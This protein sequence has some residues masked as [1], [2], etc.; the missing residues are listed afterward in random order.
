MRF[1]NIYLTL[2]S[3]PPNTFMQNL[4]IFLQGKKRFQNCSF[5]KKSKIIIKSC[6]LLYSFSQKLP[7]NG[8]FGSWARSEWLQSKIIEKTIQ[9]CSSFEKNP[10]RSITKSLGLLIFNLKKVIL[11]LQ[12]KFIIIFTVITLQLS[13]T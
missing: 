8:V 4:I 2:L 10:I 3:C 13:F 6:P 5:I 7:I 11:Q 1:V 9:P 12:L